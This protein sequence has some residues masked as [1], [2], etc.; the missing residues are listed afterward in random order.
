MGTVSLGHG[1][2]VTMENPA[3]FIRDSECSSWLLRKTALQ[4]QKRKGSGLAAL[5]KSPL[6]I[7]LR[8]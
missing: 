7:L 5:S 1:Y 4:R 3:E 8:W 6:K 2:D